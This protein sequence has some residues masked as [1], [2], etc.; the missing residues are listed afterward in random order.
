[1][2]KTKVSQLDAF[3][4]SRALREARVATEATLA[5]DDAEPVS[6]LD[7]RF[8]TFMLP[9][10]VIIPENP[11][12]GGTPGEIMRYGGYGYATFH[13]ADAFKAWKQ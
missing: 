2:Q 7:A 9:G 5:L 10:R 12:V 8:G 1:M 11:L 6:V 13:F 3:D 4:L